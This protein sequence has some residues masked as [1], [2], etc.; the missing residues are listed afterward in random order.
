MLALGGGIV[1]EGK[2]MASV[3]VISDVHG[4]RTLLRSQLESVGH[5][6]TEASDGVAALAA[7]DQQI[8]DLIIVDV[9]MPEE[10]GIVVAKL[11]I[12]LQP[13]AKILAITDS[14]P[15]LHSDWG[16]EMMQLLG[17]DAVLMKSFGNQEFL[18]SV[19]GLLA[20]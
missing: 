9:L 18:D 3:V 10:D 20:S 8:Y 15:N 7:F 2:S 19:N 17:A 11:L 16:Q 6:V 12:A 13:D 14:G 1:I 4:E 5:I